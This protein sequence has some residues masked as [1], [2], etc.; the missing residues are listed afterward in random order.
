M[1]GGEGLAPGRIERGRLD[2]S[3]PTWQEID[4]VLT[5][6][7]DLDP[8]QR[9][10]FLEQRCA[11]NS[12]LRRRVDELLAALDA[13]KDFLEQPF[14]VDTAGLWNPPAEE[15]VA[16]DRRI[17][18]Y[19]I[20]RPIGEGGSSTVYLAMRDD[21]VYQGQVA[22]KVIHRGYLADTLRQRFRAERQILAS[23]DHPYIA[24][25]LDGGSTPG[26]R[27]YIVMEAIDGQP[28]DR[29]CE[30]AG[31]ARAEIIALFRLVCEAVQYAHRYLV[32][33]R[34]LKPANILVST[35]GIPKLLDF[36]IAKLLDT[37]E[38][39]YTVEETQPGVR[40]MTPS[41]ASPEQLRGQTIT[42]ASDVFALGL[43]LH[44][45]L[46]GRLP[47]S[48]HQPSDDSRS[49]PSLEGDIGKIL[50]MALRQEPERRYASVGQF[51]EDLRRYLLGRPV[52]ARPPTFFYR[53]HK[54]LRRHRLA[55]AL[56][57]SLLGVS[58]FF[59]VHLARQVERTSAALR[60]AENERDKAQQFSDIL[61]GI[62][63][64]ADPAEARGGE[65]T[66]RELLDRGAAELSLLDD[67]PQVQSAT[68]DTIGRIYGELAQYDE[69]RALL[70]RAIDQRRQVFGPATLEVAESMAH[71]G[72]V[73]TETGDF[74]RA[75]S[76]H[77]KALDLRRDL[78]GELSEE[79]ASSLFDLATTLFELGRFDEARP[80]VETALAIRR[81]L[82]EDNR[83]ETAILVNELGRQVMAKGDF[84]GA[85]LLL[86]EALKLYGESTP[87]HP[88]LASLLNNLAV[89]M[90]QQ[91]RHSEAVAFYERALET[92]RRV[93]APDH[94]DIAMVMANMSGTLVSLG[95]LD[96]AE[97]ALQ[98]A[99]SIRRQA[100]GDAHPTVGSNLSL[101]GKVRLARGDVEGAAELYRRSVEMGRRLV[102]AEHPAL[103]GPLLALGRI[104]MQQGDPDGAEIV[105]RDAY[106]RRL[107]GFSKDHP[108]TAEAAY[109]LGRCLLSLGR[110]E[111]AETYLRE[112]LATYRQLGARGAQGAAAADELLKGSA[113]AQ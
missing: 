49:E 43:V 104:L 71:L 34:D 60:V 97:E 5:A 88:D 96:E 107:S 57:A 74:E 87:D 47:P 48:P 44:R 29:Y 110:S 50:T 81:R 100:F 86:R 3:S 69:A 73:M 79:A 106:E 39:P 30:E 83:Q 7:V 42:T 24:R 80:Y 37:S 18:P 61:F 36:G 58:A 92:R 4:E 9:Q 45:L 63:E 77:R 41:Y 27:P 25:L 70:E 102:P 76:L 59:A 2:V 11:D 109:E 52:M 10:E 78:A 22:L 103:A 21:D 6:V 28:I 17:G 40:P 65:I 105:L 16:V 38:F 68:L 13:E 84:A 108:M 89:T 51:S 32:V 26:G 95:R 35:D 82:P 53:T 20:E 64:S 67:N 62:F 33:H 90:A 72:R 12:E 113:S 46:T 85:E 1:V 23:L 66:A 8:A 14:V 15:E 75:E 112:S 54:F 19:R 111:A 94:P 101:L 98:A 93:L 31:L 56:V 55:T 91:D 99:L